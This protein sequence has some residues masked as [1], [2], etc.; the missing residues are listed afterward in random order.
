[1]FGYALIELVNFLE[2][3]FTAIRYNAFINHSLNNK[4]GQVRYPNIQGRNMPLDS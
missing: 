1:M 4:K 2:S 3:T